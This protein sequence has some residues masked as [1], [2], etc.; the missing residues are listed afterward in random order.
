[1]LSVNSGYLICIYKTIFLVFLT[2]FSK[3]F[4]LARSDVKP[5]FKLIKVLQPFYSIQTKRVAREM[6]A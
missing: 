3:R 2:I 1:M 5:I 6:H 4:G